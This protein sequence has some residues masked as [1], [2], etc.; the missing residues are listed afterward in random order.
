MKAKEIVTSALLAALSLLIPIAFGGYLKIYIP[1]FSATLA[2]HVPSMI[3]ML[4]SPT[5]AVMVGLGSSLGFLLIMG[6]V[7]AAR[8]FVHVFFGLTGALMIKKG[9]SFQKALIL[10]APIH[11]IGEALIVLPLG[12]DLYTAFVVVGI[13]TLLHHFLDSAVSVGLVKVLSS[14]LSL[15][16]KSL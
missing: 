9:L 1:P 11:A 12:F 6:P 14:G 13:G 10:V 15:S 2:S 4:V 3:S 16:S 5:A 7:V 8:A